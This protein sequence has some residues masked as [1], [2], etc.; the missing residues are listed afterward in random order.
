M[1]DIVFFILK[2]ECVTCTT[3]ILELMCSLG[4][5][6]AGKCGTIFKMMMWYDMCKLF[7][8]DNWTHGSNLGFKLP[9]KKKKKNAQR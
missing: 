3:Y 2:N 5:E 9:Q 6:V 4:A 1:C 7:T 8:K